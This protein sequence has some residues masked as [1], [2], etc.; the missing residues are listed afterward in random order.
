MRPPSGVTIYD[1]LDPAVSTSNGY[2]LRLLRSLYGI[3]DAPMLFNK[4]LD[5]FLV[6][7]GYVRSSAETSM[8]IRH[9]EA[10]GKCVIVLTEVDDLVIEKPFTAEKR[11]A[12]RV[13][14]VEEARQGD[15]RREQPASGGA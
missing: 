9:N 3:K 14:A 8:Y 4:L 1:K 12:A 6:K 11:C 10:T 5:D 15:H 7:L 2:V 13:S